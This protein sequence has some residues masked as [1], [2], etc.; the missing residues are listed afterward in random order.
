MSTEP[1]VVDVITKAAGGYRTGLTAIQETILR[2]IADGRSNRDI[3]RALDITE[4]AVSTHCSA[5]FKR[6]AASNRAHAVAIGFHRGILRRS[7]WSS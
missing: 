3:G 7:Q 4:S 1:R 2:L 6:L 5:L